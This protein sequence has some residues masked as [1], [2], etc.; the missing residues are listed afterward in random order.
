MFSFRIDDDLKL[1]LPEPQ[2]AEPLTAVVRENLA[3][4]KPWMPWATDDYSV[5]HCRQWI[6][7]TIA[8]F[9]TDGRFN[10]VII[11]KERIAGTIGFHN[12]D[13]R[14]KSAAVGYWIAGDFEGRGIVTRCVR[15]VVDYLFGTLQLNRVQI[16]C[17][18]ENLRSRA[19]PERLGFKLEG[20]HRQVELLHDR[21]GDWAVY[22]LLREEWDG[23]WVIDN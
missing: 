16:N 9:A 7:K 8:D 12:L 14:N 21:F 10:A 2:M 6:Q 23:E 19:I 18:V 3:R 22:A 17:N 1:M 15:V 4:L 20:I 11:H 13:T 5:E